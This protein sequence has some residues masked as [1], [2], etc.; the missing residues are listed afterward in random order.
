MLW[1]RGEFGRIEIATGNQ[2][3]QKKRCKLDLDSSAHHLIHLKVELYSMTRVV[4]EYLWLDIYHIFCRLA[5]SSFSS[6]AS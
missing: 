5:G 1:S 6:H 4:M 3:K 2:S